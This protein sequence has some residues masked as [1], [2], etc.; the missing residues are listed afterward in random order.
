MA[1]ITL[2]TDSWPVSLMTVE[3]LADEELLQE[4]KK[5][6]ISLVKRKQKYV[7]IIDIRE[8]TFIPDDIRV[9]FALHSRD[10]AHLFKQHYIGTIAVLGSRYM[11]TIVTAISW[12]HPFIEKVAYSAI[13]EHAEDIARK[14]LKEENIE[15][16]GLSKK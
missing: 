9:G 3:G 10:D 13:L 7:N 5:L 1:K 15:W 8:L 6:S 12:L 14:W 2:N 16:K 4:Y 11:H